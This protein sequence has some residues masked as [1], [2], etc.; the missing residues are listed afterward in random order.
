MLIRL[1]LQQYVARSTLPTDDGLLPIMT[2]NNVARFAE[3]L[4]PQATKVSPRLGHVLSSWADFL[5]VEQAHFERDFLTSKPTLRDYVQRLQSWR[6]RYEAML[7]KKPKRCPIESS[8]H[9]L[10]EFQYQ[11]FDEIEVPGQYL[12][13]NMTLLFP[14]VE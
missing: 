5:R 4:H 10:V 1:F 2:V 8:S 9:W 7:N 6:D 13:V 12:Q 11:K 14:P 3:N